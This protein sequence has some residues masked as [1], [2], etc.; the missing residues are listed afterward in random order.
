MR[1]HELP[2]VVNEDVSFYRFHLVSEI[3]C[4][5]GNGF[6]VQSLS[7]QTSG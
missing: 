5:G 3:E 2:S 1:W 4:C 6:E 7:A